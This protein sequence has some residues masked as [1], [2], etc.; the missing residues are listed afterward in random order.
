MEMN[1]E[2]YRKIFFNESRE[3]L[4]NVTESLLKAETEPENSELLNSIFRG[5]HTIK[6]SA[7]GFELN[8]ISEFA[9]H[10]ETLL[11]KIRNSEIQLSSEI[12]DL[13]LKGVDTLSE[14]INSYESGQIPEIDESLIKAFR[15]FIK[16]EQKPEE[17]PKP[18]P[19][20]MLSVQSEIKEKLK[21]FQEQGYKTYK[22]IVN[23]SDEEFVNGFDPLIFL[24]NLKNNSTFYKAYCSNESVPSINQFDPFKLYLKPEIYIATD[25]NADEIK[26]IA[27]DSSLIEV[28]EIK[29]KKKEENIPFES[30]D[31]SVIEEFLI[32]ANEALETIEKNIIEFEKNL[33][34]QSLQNILRVVHTLKG[35]SDYIG[36]SRLTK[37]AHT[38]ESVLE[39][40]KNR[41][42]TPTKETIDTILKSIDLLRTILINLKTNQGYP[43][44][45]PSLQ[46]RLEKLTK[47]AT[48]EVPTVTISEDKSAVFI[49][50]VKQ[51]REI[52]HMFFGDEKIDELKIKTITR[53]LKS[54]STISRNVGINTLSVMSEEAIKYLEKEEIQ[55][56]KKTFKDI[57]AFIEGILTGGVKRL[58]EILIEEAK[59]TEKDI[60]EALSKHKR[61]GEILVETGK[62]K[63]EDVKEALK[64]QK[65]META[66]LLKPQVVQQVEEI[67]T[68]KVDER[69]V[70]MLNNF[71]GELIVVK[72]SF[73]YLFLM[74]KDRIDHHFLRIFKDNFYQMSRV[75]RN[76]QEGIISLRMIPIKH[77]FQKF[78]RV[79][80]DIARKQGKKINLITDGEDTEID[81]KVADILSDPLIHL[82]RNACDHGIE[83]PEERKNKGKPEEGTV[84]LRAFQE[85]TNLIIK[86]IDDGRGISRKK[87]YEKAKTLGLD[88]KSPDDPEILNL[89][90][91]PGLSTK[92]K[93]SEISGRGVGMDVVKTTVE[94]LGGKVNVVSEEEKGTEITL[95]LP[96]RIGI[97]QSLFVKADERLYAIPIEF[98]VETK[99]VDLSNIKRVHDRLGIYWRGKIIP[100]E[101]L[102]VLLN[103][104]NRTNNKNDLTNREVSVVILKTNSGEF[105]II[106]DELHKNME[107]AVKPLPEELKDLELISGV[108]IMGDGRIVLVLNIETLV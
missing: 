103:G 63:E 108:S 88:V 67:K 54:L 77:I 42:L 46:E 65:L 21:D 37:F 80:R 99:K 78:N 8:Q 73:E 7:G 27:F 39:A 53:A 1:M 72:N 5:I 26:D 86:I 87:V 104:G 35:D 75:S 98:V 13:I 11:D 36:L 102:S 74:L 69:K 82:V 19:S 6:G 62:V 49:E 51:F 4:E 45:L 9:H 64:K 66:S 20:G 84:I 91:L 44:D 58:G 107:I 96:T 40:L 94:S 29:E 105:G 95:T 48:S 31:S 24:K 56:F 18:Q 106:V 97:L 55:D 61:I 3:I 17:K 47:S 100:V 43:L 68:L 89:I 10:M 41:T 83:T 60:E 101:K 90:F 81:K 15:G 22:V 71:I 34:S 25:L 23:Y 79:V 2:Y 76:L 16:K 59:I 52:I 28:I 12:V 32:D 93:V 92:E 57:D 50:Q 85:G 14:M 70:E 30:I 38:L 33:S